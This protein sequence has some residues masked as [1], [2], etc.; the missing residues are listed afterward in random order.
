MGLVLERDGMAIDLLLA[1]DLI[2]CLEMVMRLKDDGASCLIRSDLRR[3]GSR[4]L[5]L[6]PGSDVSSS[7]SSS[8]SSDS[9][10]SYTS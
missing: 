7:S 2:G 6:C 4:T 1:V 5:P 9:S 10:V 3:A 8:S